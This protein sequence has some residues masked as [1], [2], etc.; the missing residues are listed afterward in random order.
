MRLNVVYL[1]L[2]QFREFVC[3]GYFGKQFNRNCFNFC[4]NA[5]PWSVKLWSNSIYQ[6][7]LFTHSATFEQFPET[8]NLQLPFAQDRLCGSNWALHVFCCA[9]SI[10]CVCFVTQLLA[11]ERYEIEW[12]W[13]HRREKEQAIVAF[14]EYKRKHINTGNR[15]TEISDDRYVCSLVFETDT[16]RCYLHRAKY[17]SV[18]RSRQ[19][20]IRILAY[21]FAPVWPQ[22]NSIQVNRQNSRPY[23]RKKSQKN[24]YLDIPHTL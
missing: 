3:F 13:K 12:S 20:L 1:G 21:V 8:T 19:K 15:K 17:W 11:D 14:F 18:Y 7:C 9:P 16:S 2:N 24:I 6:L 5:T 22:R 23:I 4:R 10:S